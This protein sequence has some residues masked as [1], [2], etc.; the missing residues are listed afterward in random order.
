[1]CYSGQR[2]HSFS[3]L[4]RSFLQACWAPCSASPTC[5]PVRWAAWHQTTPPAAS[6]CAAASGPCGSCRAWVSLLHVVRCKVRIC[7]FSG[8]RWRGR[9]WTLWT[10]QSLGERLL[11]ASRMDFV[12]LGDAMAHLLLTGPALCKSSVVFEQQ[13]ASLRG[14]GCRQLRQ[15]HQPLLL[16]APMCRRRVLHPHVLH[17]ALPGSNHGDRGLLVHLRAHGLRS[18]LC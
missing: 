18:H 2:M 10:V 7:W 6:A 11:F 15:L 16:P 14:C 8:A 5:L 12:G 13:C 3:A 9:L 17:L 4:P 1:M